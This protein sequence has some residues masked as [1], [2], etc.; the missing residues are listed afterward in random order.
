MNGLSV[1]DRL[2][3][4]ELA[5]RY[6]V[7]VDQHDWD[8]AADLFARG[9]VL[10]TP[11]PP[12]TL[13]PALEHAGRDAVRDAVAQLRTFAR[14][15]HHVT[16]SVWES[17]GD[18]AAGR[19]T[20]VAQH[21]EAGPE[22]RSWVW[23]LVYDDRCVRSPDGWQFARRALTLMIVEARPVALVLPFGPAEGR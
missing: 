21:V 9:G 16:G 1:E 12:R 3:L 19:T 7:S 4:A 10:V 5:A 2:D 22:P 20:A 18:G 17:D 13:L 14:T 15:V 8:G 11:D 23:H 6:A